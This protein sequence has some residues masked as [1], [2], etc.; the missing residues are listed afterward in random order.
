[1][2]ALVVVGGLPGTGKS[3]IAEHAARFLGAALLSKDIFEA[4]LW[5]NGITREANA[6]WASYDQLGAVAELQLRIGRP[7]VIDSV[8][9]NERIR[10]AWRDIAGRHSAHFIA[11]ECVCS[12]EGLHRSR[13]AERDRGILGWP[14]VTW[15]QVAEI[16]TRYEPWQTEHLVLDAIR[17]LDENLAT[18]AAHLRAR[19]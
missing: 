3:I 7:A 15:E 14:E 13:L 19:S 8:A 2:T 1:M 11:V 9:T 5:R 18:L 10:S 6:G 4:A 12:D 16:R 17:P